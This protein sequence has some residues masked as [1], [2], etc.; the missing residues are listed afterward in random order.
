MKKKF[1]TEMQDE[2]RAEYDLKRLLKQGV[3]GKY[4]KRYHKGTNL[5]LLDP[6][7]AR[8]FQNADAVNEALRLVI[9][10]T[11]IPNGKHRVKAL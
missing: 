2:L 6:Q 1:K 9:R 5:V 11:K 4:A 10:L 7:V 8:A 3:L